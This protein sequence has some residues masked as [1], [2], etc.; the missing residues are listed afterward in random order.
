[1]G[2]WGSA[3][4]SGFWHQVWHQALDWK[5][6]QNPPAPKSPGQSGA[7]HA[8]LYGALTHCCL[9]RDLAGPGGLVNVLCHQEASAPSCCWEVVWEDPHFLT[10]WAPWPC[11]STHCDPSHTAG[12]RPGRPRPRV[13][14]LPGSLIP[15]APPEA[16]S[17]GET[18]WQV[19]SWC[20]T[21]PLSLSCSLFTG[22]LILSPLQGTF[23]PQTLQW[24][25]SCWTC[26]ASRAHFCH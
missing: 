11:V 17:P 2:G 16:S 26:R 22:P 10:L 8:L 18:C 4:G 14:A 12:A 5:E 24:S 9:H 23:V 19:L 25:P 1:M 15:R 6:P 13:P 7:S 20:H 21:L 3:R